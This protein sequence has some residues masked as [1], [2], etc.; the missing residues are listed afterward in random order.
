MKTKLKPANLK[1]YLTLAFIIAITGIISCKKEDKPLD[2][3]G[4][5]ASSKKIKTS[6]RLNALKPGTILYKAS[7]VSLREQINRNVQT[8]IDK[9][10][11]IIA[12]KGESPMFPF[13]DCPALFSST[14]V[15]KQAMVV[16]GNFCENT[17]V[18]EVRFI[19]NVI[20]RNGYPQNALSYQFLVQP[21]IIFGSTYQGS[22]VLTNTTGIMCVPDWGCWGFNKEYEVVVVMDYYNY[23]AA[24]TNNTVTGTSPCKGQTPVTISNTCSLDFPCSYYTTIPA[25]A[26]ISGVPTGVNVFTDCSICQVTPP[27]TICPNSVTFT[28]WPVNNPN[29]TTTTTLPGSGGLIV[30][31]QGIYGYSSYTTYNCGNSQTQSGSFTVG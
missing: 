30:L 28:Y 8:E 10:K 17:A 9:H 13:H 5:K 23:T 21:N 29:Q 6:E 25:R 16:S 14:S 3:E 15:L 1:K 7:E 19:W 22:A 20:E 24:T 4:S 18:V 12:G 11:Q 26:Y 27:H 31:P 2:V